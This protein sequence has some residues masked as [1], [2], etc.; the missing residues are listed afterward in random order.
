VL[1]YSKGGLPICQAE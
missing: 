1:F